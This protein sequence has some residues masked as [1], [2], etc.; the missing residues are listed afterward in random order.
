ML[1]YL[2][3]FIIL[4]ICLFALML[5]MG[6]GEWVERIGCCE[7]TMLKKQQATPETDE[8]ETDE[9]ASKRV[10]D[11]QAPKRIKP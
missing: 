2:G 1:K 8:L 5:T 4:A 6:G 10:T 3:I 11:E 9:P 7:E